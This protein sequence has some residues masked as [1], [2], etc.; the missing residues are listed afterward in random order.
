MFKE[1]DK[2]AGSIASEPKAPRWVLVLGCYLRLGVNCLMISVFIY[3]MCFN[4]TAYIGFQKADHLRQLLASQT[5]RTHAPI[6]PLQPGMI[7]STLLSAT[8][9]GWM[10]CNRKTWRLRPDQKETERIEI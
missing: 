6:S 5:G 9:V 1:M 3:V 7:F 8:M 2:I 4:A 10:V